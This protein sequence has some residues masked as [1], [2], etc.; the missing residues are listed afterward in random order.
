MALCLAPLLGCF[1]QIEDPSVTMTHSLCAANANC[2]PGGPGVP[3][4][5]S[6]T[7]GNTFT[8]AFGDQPLLKP[9][10]S[11]GPT[12]LN[13]SL[14][15]NQATFD[16]KTTGADFTQVDSVKLLAAIQPPNPPTADPCATPAN[17]V[18]IAIFQKSTDG[19]ANQQIVL[20]GNGSD[21]L[22]Y[23]N[24]TTHDLT[25]QIQATGFAPTVPWNADVA[26]D[27]ALKSRAKFP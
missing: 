22:T 8:V 25:V 4:S 1:A 20:K 18:L 2:I 26:M 10:S 6:T 21:V 11:L 16:M 19:V 24:T 3:L 14:M 9:T 15:L 5:V 17:C 23:I 13:S 27:M 7:G 12:T